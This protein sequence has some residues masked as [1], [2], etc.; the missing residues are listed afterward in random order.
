MRKNMGLICSITSTNNGFMT[1]E[2][3]KEETKSTVFPLDWRIRQSKLLNPFRR[4]LCWKTRRSIDLHI[5]HQ[6]ISDY[7]HDEK[8]KFNINLMKFFIVTMLP[9]RTVI[10]LMQEAPPIKTLLAFSIISALLTLGVVITL[11]VLCYTGF[12]VTYSSSSTCG[13]SYL[14]RKFET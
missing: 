11:S 12:G 9:W 8:L 5:T 7:W 6:K 3:W 14:T 2:A 10:I 4:V 13:I 1:L